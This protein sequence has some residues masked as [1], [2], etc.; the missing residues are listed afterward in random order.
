MRPWPWPTSEVTWFSTKAFKALKGHPRRRELIEPFLVILATV[1]ID[2]SGPVRSLSGWASRLDLPALARTIAATED[3]Y[4]RRFAEHE[5]G[6]MR[7]RGDLIH[8]RSKASW[9]DIRTK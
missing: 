5:A 3:V 6:A 4:V 7:R 8:L 1:G 2:D 9:W